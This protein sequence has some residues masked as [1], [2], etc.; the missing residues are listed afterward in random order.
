MR[1]TARALA[2][3]GGRAATPRLGGD[4]VMEPSS[5]DLI[6]MDQVIRGD[7]DKEIFR[8]TDKPPRAYAKYN[9]VLRAD[10]YGELLKLPLRY[11]LHPY[12]TLASAASLSAVG[13]F[14]PLGVADPDDTLPFFVHRDAEGH[15]MWR[16]QSYNPRNLNPHMFMVIKGIDGDMFRF[17]DELVK[18]FPTKKIFMRESFVHVYSVGEDA[19]EVLEHWLLGLGF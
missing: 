9:R 19:C 3:L 11:K 14:P 12:D 13:Y 6:Q 4:Q 16:L 15:F 1:R 5:S 18:V 7:L 10:L 17:E 8:A 2:W